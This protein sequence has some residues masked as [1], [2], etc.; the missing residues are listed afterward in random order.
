MSPP[1]AQY[2]ETA[3]VAARATSDVTLVDRRISAHGGP[4][5]VATALLGLGLGERLSW[6]T[7]PFPRGAAELSSEVL[8]EIVA[9]GK[10]AGRLLLRA[11][12]VR[13]GRTNPYEFELRVKPSLDQPATVIRKDQYDMVM[14]VLN[15]FHPIGVEVRTDNVRAHV[16]EVAE[17][18]LEALPAYTFPSYRVGGLTASDPTRPKEDSHAD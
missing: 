12:Y 4:T 1:A 18:L 15:S 13:P 16:V 5:V 11:L 17:E 8:P 10:A 6:S 3:I 7:I 9:R 14:N 2:L